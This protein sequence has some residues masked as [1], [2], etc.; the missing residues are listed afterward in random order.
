MCFLATCLPHVWYTVAYIPS[1][2][3]ITIRAN[4]MRSWEQG[5][6]GSPFLSV[7]WATEEDQFLNTLISASV[8][9]DN[10]IGLELPS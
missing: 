3:Q 1:A 5:L 6:L 2:A 8:N 4:K 7:V 10:V 9:R